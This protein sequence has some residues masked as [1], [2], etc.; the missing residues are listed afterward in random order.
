MPGL[1]FS[2][3]DEATK[4]VMSTNS[5]GLKTSSN[6][7]VSFDDILNSKDKNESNNNGLSLSGSEVI[8]LNNNVQKRKQLKSINYKK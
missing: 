1:L 6:N 7:D 8:E 4:K 2:D 3:P 5:S